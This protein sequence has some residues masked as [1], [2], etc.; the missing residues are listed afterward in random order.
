[1]MPEQGNLL[2]GAPDFYILCDTKKPNTMKWIISV[3]LMLSFGSAFSQ[4]KVY[5]DEFQDLEKV[6]TGW[7]S[8]RRKT[9]LSGKP[10]SLEGVVY[11]RGI[12]IHAYSTFE[13]QL[14]G[15]VQNFYCKLGLDGM[16]SKLGGHSIKVGFFA[17]GK[18]I[19]FADSIGPESPAQE[20]KLDLPGKKRLKVEIEGFP[21][22][23][24]THCDLADAHFVYSGEKP[25]LYFRP[26]EAATILTPQPGVKPRLTGPKVFG[27]RPDSPILFR[28]TATGAKPIR[29]SAKGLPEGIVLDENTGILKGSS[30]RSGSFPI[31]VM[32]S[33][34]QGTNSRTWTLKIGNELCLTPPLGWNSWNCW[35]MSVDADKIRKAGKA[36]VASG[37]ADHGW[38]FINIDDG[39]QGETRDPE[40]GV[41]LSDPQKFPDMEKLATDIHE[42]GLKIGLYSSPGTLTCGK[43]LGSLGHEEIDAQTYARWG[44]D[45][46]KYDYCSYSQVVKMDSRKPYFGKRP[47]KIMQ[48]ALRKQS[49]DIV[50]SLCQYGEM[51][52][53]KWGASVDG[54]LWRTTGDIIDTWN[55]MR[56]I[57]FRQGAAAPYTKPGRWADPDMLVLGQVGWGPKL[58]PS[59][60][61]PN[62]QYTH[63]SL[64]CML[65]APLLLGCDLEALDPF[66]LG[67]LTNDEVL[68]INQDPL[69]QQATEVLGNDSRKVYLKKLENGDMA[70]AIFN[71]DEQEMQTELAWKDLG[72]EGNF[73]VRDLWRQQDLKTNGKLWKGTVPL[74]GVQLF[75]LRKKA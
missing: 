38:S 58:H 32:A 45:Y 72:L 23:W 74:H 75:R 30:T 24:H 8:P 17:D 9:N 44:Y 7:S 65:S 61:T 54:N 68:D 28:F 59:R 46:L 5:L 40:T 10:L 29:F 48:E 2:W 56:V 21:G 64:W 47:Y 4:K 55:S 11:E 63:F 26:T 62:E 33:N 3:A 19:W 35:G 73:I 60:L 67:L 52:V 71:L 6:E 43:K 14:D 42:M 70:I 57:G 18:R 50:Y 53:W 66:T 37:L 34:A 41:I 15:K 25:S 22:T 69:G 1:M 13:V 16:V 51:E 12:C 36:M 20:I 27:L 39:W 31:E 49:R